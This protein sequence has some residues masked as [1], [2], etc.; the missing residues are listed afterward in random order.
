M[1][2]VEAM[3]HVKDDVVETYP[4]GVIVDRTARAHRSARTEE[5]S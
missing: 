5:T 4:L 1:T 2:P 3:A